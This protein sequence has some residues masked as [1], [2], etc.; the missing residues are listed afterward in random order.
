MKMT[1]RLATLAACAV[2]GASA[3]CV[4]MSVSAQNIESNIDLCYNQT[5]Y[6]NPLDYS[7]Y[8]TKLSHY[9]QSGMSW[10][11]KPCNGVSGATIGSQGCA[12]TSF[13]MILSHNDKTDN[14]GDVADKLKGYAYPSFSWTKAAEEYGLNKPTLTYYSKS[15]SDKGRANSAICSY[16]RSNTPVIV[17]LEN[18]Y[19]SSDTHFVVARGAAPQNA[20]VYIFDPSYNDEHTVLDE[21][22]NENYF[23]YEIIVF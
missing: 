17:G 7:K 20:N 21:Y 10:S 8:V 11:N 6:S 23:V 9:Y 18:K 15:I 1:K 3:L 12:I 2:M 22:Y 4:P 5:T 19:D 14:P 16:V 13:A